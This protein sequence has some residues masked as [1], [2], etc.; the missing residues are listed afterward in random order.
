[1]HVFTRPSVTRF[2][3]RRGAPLGAGVVIAAVAAGSAGAAGAA[4]RPTVG[5]V[6]T[7]VSRLTTAEDRAVQQYDQV[8][9]QLSTAQARLQLV[10]AE[11]ARNETQFRQIHRE[12]AQVAST[13]YETASLSIAGL[14]TSGNPGAVLSKAAVLTQLSSDRH[15]AM[16]QFIAAAAR[17][18]AR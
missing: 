18:S 4:P 16:T 9:Q 1:M 17:V 7:Q 3:V 15:A 8:K 2:L 11:L 6:R 12:V 10:S 5:Q 13:A 14:L